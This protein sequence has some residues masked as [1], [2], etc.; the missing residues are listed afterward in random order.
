MHTSSPYVLP[1][2]SQNLEHK[3]EASRP[4]RT[5]ISFYFLHSQDIRYIE[6]NDAHYPPF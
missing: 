3:I 4:T 1:T 6:K 5:E 2:N